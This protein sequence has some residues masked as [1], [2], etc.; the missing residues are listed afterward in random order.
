VNADERWVLTGEAYQLIRETPGV[1]D[2]VGDRDKEVP[3]SEDDV[4]KVLRLSEPETA[5]E[6][7]VVRVEFQKGD[8]VKIK[9]GPFDGFEG[10]IEE[11]DPDKGMVQVTVTIFGRPTPVELEH[12]QVQKV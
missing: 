6:E 10:L 9:D 11:V 7:P 3:M 4:R 2:F 12:W 1:G 5:G 8:A